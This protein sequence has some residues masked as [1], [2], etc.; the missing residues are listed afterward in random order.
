MMFVVAGCVGFVVG[1]AV[2]AV[3]ARVAFE[4][5]LDKQ[6]RHA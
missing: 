1:F 4:C 2:A 5:W 6:G 3:C